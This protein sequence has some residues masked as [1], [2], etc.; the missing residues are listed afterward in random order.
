MASL[1]K[2]INVNP[3]LLTD[4]DMLLM[5]EKGIRGRICQE[6]HR[7]ANANNKYMKNYN[8]DIISSY[9][10]YLDVNSLYGWAMSQ[11]LTINDFKWV[12]KSKLSRFNEK[13]ITNYNESSD[14]GYFLK[15]DADYPKELFNLHNALPFLPKWKKA[16]KCERL[17]CSI[18]DKEKHVVHIRALKQVLN[19]G[20]ILKKVH[21]VLKFNQRAWLKPYIDMNNKK[22]KE[23]KNIFEKDLFKLMNN[24]VFG[25]IMENLRKH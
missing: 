25:K 2:K 20:L 16:N 12:E 8:K 14:I 11:T 22:R 5:V 15:V 23:T 4:I 6:I 24:S 1:P 17:I 10:R 19:H 7:H 18:E 21:R 9:L 3:A 13:F